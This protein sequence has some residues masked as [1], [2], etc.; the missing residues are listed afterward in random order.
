MHT[1]RAV[2]G[3]IAGNCRTGHLATGC[4][5]HE[6]INIPHKIHTD[7]DEDC[8]KQIFVDACSVTSEMSVTSYGVTSS[9]N[10]GHVFLTYSNILVDS[11]AGKNEECVKCRCT[12]G[13]GE[14]RLRECTCTN[15]K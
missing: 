3:A 4:S 1:N 12:R 7:M 14:G 13:V 6:V 5:S 11:L 10:F 9:A 2:Y 8:H 15:L